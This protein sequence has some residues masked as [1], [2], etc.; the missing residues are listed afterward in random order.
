[1]LG[2]AT[3][4]KIIGA[5]AFKGTA[6]ENANI[7]NV[8]TIGESAFEGC[9]ALKA[10]NIKGV[11]GTLGSSAFKG[12]VALT[13]VAFGG[14]ITAINPSAFEGC[15][16]LA[17][18]D[19]SAAENL[20]NIWGS[21]F[22]GCA[23]L[24]SVDLSATAVTAISK[25]T[26]FVGCTELAE[27]ILPEGITNLAA[28]IFADTKIAELDLSKAALTELK[29][30]FG[31]WDEETSAFKANDEAHPNTTLK[32]LKL[33]D[34]EIP[35]STFAYFTALETVEMGNGLVNEKAFANCTSLTSFT[36]GNSHIYSNAFENDAK[37]ETV[38]MGDGIVSA[39]AFYMCAAL[40]T[41]DYA[42]DAATITNEINDNAFIGCTYPVIINTINSYVEAHPT[43]PTNAKYGTGAI[44]TVKTV[45]DNGGSGK[46]YMYFHN[47]NTNRA[48][49]NKADGNF[50]SIYVDEG[51][52][53]FQSVRA[54][55]GKI[56]VKKGENI[57]IKT[58]EEKEVEYTLTAT[59][60]AKKAVLV[61]E[62][63]CLTADKALVDFQTAPGVT[64]SD[65]TAVTFKAGNYIYR[66]TNK[67]PQG[68]G[69]S[70]YT[71]ATMKAG[72][73][74]IISTKAPDAAG[75]LQTV[76]LDEDGNVESDAT[77]IQKVEAAEAQDG[78]IYNLQGVRVN[79]AKKGLYI[80]NGK[81][82]IVK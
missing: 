70:Y 27:F 72:Q 22:K 58:D 39:K 3:A 10:V 31:Y 63:I 55:D 30:M 41:F 15:E 45:K 35:A 28:N 46:Y 7:P 73:F 12:C 64:Y 17:T 56:Y 57:I 24:K 54:I 14:E 65:G 13:K 42:K 69:F 75:R 51:I 43:A 60:P 19:F 62:V 32:T 26:T 44:L 76:W 37:L 36:K 74:F 38:V 47:D 66:L 78:A 18:A 52:A 11:K 77:A 81:K 29:D 16:A 2:S 34:I 79:A 49:F 40:K 82:F 21:A 50:Y 71:G 9:E 68:F 48:V 25:S 61:D 59:D 5:S 1:V 53:Y 33:G 67:A 4:L 8:E 20:T 80:Q 6:T 23:A